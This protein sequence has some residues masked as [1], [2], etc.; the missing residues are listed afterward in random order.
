MATAS[1]QLV[2]VPVISLVEQFT[3]NLDRDEAQVL[4]DILGRIGG[5]PVASRRRFATPILRALESA[6]TFVDDSEDYN[7]VSSSENSI[8]FTV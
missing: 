8:Y 2:E 3:I 1:K 4:H 6:A 7:D 5:D